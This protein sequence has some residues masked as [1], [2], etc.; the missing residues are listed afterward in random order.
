MIYN[1]LTYKEKMV[2][3]VRIELTTSAL[4]RMR[5]TTELRQHGPETRAEAALWRMV[6]PA[7]RL[8]A[9]RAICLGK[10][11]AQ[12]EDERAKRLAEALR[13]NLRRRKAQAR[14][15]DAPAAA[16][17]DKDTLPS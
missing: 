5:S 11:M 7:S 2:L 14:G 1:Y 15:E 3:P 12:A 8:A 9:P 16:E 6:R 4:P 17:P 13:A 10:S